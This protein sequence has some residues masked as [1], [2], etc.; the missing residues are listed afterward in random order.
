MDDRGFDGWKPVRRRM[1]KT[2]TQTAITPKKI[3]TPITMP[4]MAPPLKAWTVG[5]GDV[6]GGGGGRDVDVENNET[7]RLFQAM[8]M[9]WR[10]IVP[11]FTGTTTGVEATGSVKVNVDTY[12]KVLCNASV[13]LEP[14]AVVTT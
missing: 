14:L 12:V 6:V 11:G 10:R 13:K 9:G 4:A 2:Q 3:K 8:V 7:S 1:N 5:G